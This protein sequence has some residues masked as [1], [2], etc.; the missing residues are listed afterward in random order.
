M[1]G[2]ISS[3]FAHIHQL[4]ILVQGFAHGPAAGVE[5]GT[6]PD[7]DLRGH[8]PFGLI[9]DHQTVLA[10][11]HDIE[12]E[13]GPQEPVHRI[14]IAESIPGHQET[15]ILFPV[16]SDRIVDDE[17]VA[18]LV[19][20]DFRI[21]LPG[22]G[23]AGND[24]DRLRI[25][26][27]ERDGLDGTAQQHGQTVGENSGNDLSPAGFDDPGFLFLRQKSNL[28]LF[29]G[30]RYHTGRKDEDGGDPCDFHACSFLLNSHRNFIQYNMKW[31]RIQVRGGF[32]CG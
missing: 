25:G 19:F 10:H 31:K 29:R 6:F 15:D 20:E 12:T 4:D 21:F 9:R 7:I 1:P 14:E 24:E 30:S 17:A 27:F 2:D 18:R 16:E 23:F 11:A 26:L 3:A 22:G 32:F 28:K 5:R 8:L 13:L